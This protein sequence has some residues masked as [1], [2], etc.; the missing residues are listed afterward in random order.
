MIYVIS[1]LL[2]DL[3]TPIRRKWIETNINQVFPNLLV[4]NSNSPNLWPES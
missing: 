4:K 1:F 2:S 3:V